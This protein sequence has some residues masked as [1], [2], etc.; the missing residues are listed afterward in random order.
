[1]DRILFFTAVVI[2]VFGVLQIVLF[3]KMWGMTN[4]VRSIKDMMEKYI[5]KIEKKSI[6]T[7]DDNGYKGIKI[8]DLVVDIKTKRKMTVTN[9]TSEGKYECKLT[10]GIAPIGMFNRDEI[11]LFDVFYKK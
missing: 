4:N 10:G 11:E 8:E 1:M 3:F 5:S 9:V 6:G 2:L 7:E